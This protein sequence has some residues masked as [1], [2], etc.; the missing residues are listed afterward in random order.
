MNFEE[1]GRQMFQKQTCEVVFHLVEQMEMFFDNHI[2]LWFL[3]VTG[4]D[5]NYAVKTEVT[6]GKEGSLEVFS[7][8]SLLL[9]NGTSIKRDGQLQRVGREE[10]EEGRSE[11]ITSKVVAITEMENRIMDF[12][13]AYVEQNEVCDVFFCNCQQY[14]ILNYPSYKTLICKL[15]TMC[16]IPGTVTFKA[17]E[18]LLYG[19]PGS[20]N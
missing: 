9:N 20:R 18:T 11:R 14:N 5:S 1:K 4:V 6:G 2:M 7:S 17:P 12:N 8:P 10:I 19:N 15:F 13:L 16:V 3:L